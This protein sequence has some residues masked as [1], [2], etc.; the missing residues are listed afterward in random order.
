MKANEALKFSGE[1]ILIIS[2]LANRLKYLLHKE[3]HNVIKINDLL[4]VL[5]HFS[6]IP[7]ILDN[8]V[9]YLNLLTFQDKISKLSYSE[10]DELRGCVNAILAKIEAHTDFS[11]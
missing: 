3:P 11:R 10:L 6:L 2:M 4:D 8:K 9:G 1:I 5:S 7:T